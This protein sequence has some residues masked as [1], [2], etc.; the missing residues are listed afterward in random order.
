M[1]L[2]TTQ[3]WRK[4]ETVVDT[5]D[6]V[7]ETL[8]RQSDPVRMHRSPGEGEGGLPQWGSWASQVDDSLMRRISDITCSPPSQLSGPPS[9]YW[10]QSHH[11]YSGYQP[12]AT[13]VYSRDDSSPLRRPSPQP[14][15]EATP[16]LSH[17]L[18]WD[19]L[20]P[21]PCLPTSPHSPLH[22]SVPS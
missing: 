9:K 13:P 3:L 15:T 10:G 22:P 16:C 20:F 5:R 14:P 18:Q 1:V 6:D 21:S 11:T 4:E 17:R 2:H 8:T 7:I 12:P 19:E